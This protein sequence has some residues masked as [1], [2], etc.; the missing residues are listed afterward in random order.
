MIQ[1]NA[2]FNLATTCLTTRNSQRERQGWKAPSFFSKTLTTAAESPFS[3]GTVERHNGIL[4]E[5]MVNTQKDIGCD[6]ETALAWVVS[7]KNS[8]QNHGGFSPNQLV[9]GH[10]INM[11][12]V[13]TDKVPAFESTTSSEI[14]RKNLEA[15]HTARTKFIEAESSE[16][17]RRALHKKVRSYADVKYESGDKVFYFIFFSIKLFNLHY[18]NKQRAYNIEIKSIKRNYYTCTE[19]Y[20][21]LQK[22]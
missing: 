9:F 22:S 6:P 13:L 3:N 19:P 11:P 15:L 21:P 7:T 1:L 12:T 17:I 16:R 14:L 8:L 5:A 10:N 20:E 2:V 4:Y 18:T